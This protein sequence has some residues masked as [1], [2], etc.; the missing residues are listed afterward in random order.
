ME[1]LTARELLQK[2]RDNTI[3]AEERQ[4]LEA[5]Y[6]DYTDRSESFNDI[7]AFL[8]D[9]EMLDQVFLP[10]KPIPPKT[11]IISLPSLGIAAAAAVILISFGIYFVN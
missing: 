7:Q 11:S 8:E 5:W 1:R 4:I 3:S 2:L 9:M 6:V 10:N